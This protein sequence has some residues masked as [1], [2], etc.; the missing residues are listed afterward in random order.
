MIII[1]IIIIII[2]NCLPAWLI[3]LKQGNKG[4]SWFVNKADSPR[5]SSRHIKKSGEL[6]NSTELAKIMEDTTNE[7]IASSG[8]IACLLRLF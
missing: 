8:A 7:N 6:K 5:C 1:I 4:W 3:Q 2:I